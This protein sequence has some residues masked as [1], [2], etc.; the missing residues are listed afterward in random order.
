MSP[1]PGAIACLFALL[2]A[3]G[4]IGWLLDRYRARECQRQVEAERAF[5][6]GM[7]SAHRRGWI[8]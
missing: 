3:L 2:A 5:R 8:P 1:V 4:A 6:I 7:H